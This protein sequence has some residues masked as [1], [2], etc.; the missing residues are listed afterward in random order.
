MSVEYKPN[1]R[2][3][4]KLLNM[5]DTV[6]YKVARMTLDVAV[7]HIPM[8]RGLP[9]SGQLRRSSMV[10]GVRGQDGHYTIGSVTSYAIYV[11]NMPNGTNWTTPNTYGKWF[12]KTFN[13]HQK[14][15]IQNAI[16][17]ARKE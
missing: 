14:V 8:S 10:Y 9:T 1:L 4:Q 3:E 15:F 2:T 5:G 12:H 11:Y 7:P 16:D 13:A 17:Q 6:M